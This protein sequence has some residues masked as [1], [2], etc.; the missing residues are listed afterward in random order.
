MLAI[1]A[2]MVTLCTLQSAFA[3]TLVARYNPGRWQG[4]CDIQLT[5]EAKTNKQ[6]AGRGSRLCDMAC[7]ASVDSDL[8]PW[9]STLFLKRR[10]SYGPEMVCKGGSWGEKVNLALFFYFLPREVMIF[11]QFLSSVSWQQ[12]DIRCKGSI[13]SSFMMSCGQ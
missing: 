13:A 1:P 4:W 8:G 10:C 5:D 12:R 3:H 9:I 11:Q 6:Q 7:V 2:L